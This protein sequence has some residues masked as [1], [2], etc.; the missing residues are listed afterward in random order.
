[1]SKQEALEKI[2]E[3]L[4]QVFNNNFPCICG[5]NPLSDKLTTEDQEKLEKILLVLDLLKD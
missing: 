3:K 2:C 1:M 5:H 4:G